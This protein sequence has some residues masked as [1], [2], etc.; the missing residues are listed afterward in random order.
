MGI[1]SKEGRGKRVSS[2]S[3]IFMFEVPVGYLSELGQLVI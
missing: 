3:N 2:V 1:H